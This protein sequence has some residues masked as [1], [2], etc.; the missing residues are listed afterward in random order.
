MITDTP[1]PLD[2]VDAC[3]EPQLCGYGLSSDR[4]WITCHGENIL[5]LPSE[6][7]P[8]EFVISGATVGIGCANGRVLM[9][10]FL[11]AVLPSGGRYERVKLG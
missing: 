7:R 5:W 8:G 9:I 2:G 11:P 3:Q 4:S 10:C 6:Y 1:T